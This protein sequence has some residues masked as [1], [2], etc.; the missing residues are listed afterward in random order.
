[1]PSSEAKAAGAARAATPK[2]QK[3]TVATHGAN[4][5]ADD[6]FA[7]AALSL[8]FKKKNIAW[9]L[10]RTL[11]QAVLDKADYVMDIGSVHDERK[12]RFDHHQEGGAGVRDSGIPYAAFGLVWKKFGKAVAG[13]EE[14]AEYVDGRLIAPLDASDNG[15]DTFE[16]IFEK[17]SPVTIEDYIGD[18][19]ILEKNKPKE[20]QDF[21]ASFKRLIPFAERVI[22]LHIE[23]GVSRM[24]ADRAIKKAYNKSEDKRIVVSET[25]YPFDFE[26]YPEVLF[27]VYKDL[28]GNWSAKTIKKSP[29]SYESRFSFPKE[30]WGKRDEE[31]SAASGVSGAIFCHNS[32]FLAVAETKNGALELARKAL[33]HG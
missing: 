10:L 19:C 33:M 32:G 22:L 18:E 20:E 14:V 2:P 15:V 5:H 1:M 30:W 17:V 9:R 21:D 8:Y 27:Y 6:L 23:K 31:L 3:V 28:R 12:N 26:E 7:V 16:P 4:Y 13:S 24:K 11:D 29:G 25:F